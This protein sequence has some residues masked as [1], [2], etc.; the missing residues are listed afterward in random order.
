MTSLG[1]VLGLFV[2]ETAG[3]RPKTPPK[4]SY[5]KCFRWTQ[6]RWVIWLSSRSKTG[7]LKGWCT[8]SFLKMCTIPTRLP[9][10]C[11]SRLLCGWYKDYGVRHWPSMISASSKPTWISTPLPPLG[12]LLGYLL[13]RGCEFE[14]VYSHSLKKTRKG[15]G[16]FKFLAG[17]DKKMLTSQNPRNPEKLKVT[18]KVTK[19]WLSGSPPK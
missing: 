5:S 1:G 11:S 12:P 8:N 15:C 3:R 16:C 13:R 10:R 19:K 4:K 17:R 18:P 7:I 9:W 14:W 6:I 2:R